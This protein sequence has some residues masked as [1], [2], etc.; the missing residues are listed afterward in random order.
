[1]KLK[2]F[3]R[4]NNY[5]GTTHMSSL[6]YILLVISTS[7]FNNIKFFFYCPLLDGSCNNYKEKYVIKW[8]KFFFDMSRNRIKIDVDRNGAF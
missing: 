5:K 1:M 4:F 8:A 7:P 6:K 2:I 3:K